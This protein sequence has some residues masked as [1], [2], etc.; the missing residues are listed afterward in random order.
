MRFSESWRDA[1][2]GEVIW[3][4]LPLR[5]R[6]LAC[7]LR[8]AIERDLG[9]SDVGGQEHTKDPWI[10]A[11]DIARV[12]AREERIVLQHDAGVRSVAGAREI[13]EA[14]Q[15]LG[16]DQKQRRALA[17]ERSPKPRQGA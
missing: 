17:R 9:H 2:A 6:L 1:E 7:D 11:P 14:H 12:V 10:V 13:R 16:L 3:D 8:Q 4:C 5:A 15:A